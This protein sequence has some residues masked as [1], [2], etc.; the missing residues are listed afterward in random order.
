M[1]KILA[2]AIAP[3]LATAPALA[4]PG[5]TKTNV[6]FRSGPGANF[7][8][9]RSL[10]AGTAVDIGDCDAAGSWCAVAVKGQKGFVSG[11]YLQESKDTD[12]WPRAYTV[13]R[14]RIVLH[15][16]QFTEWTDFKTIEALV[17]A[18][19][20]KSEDARP[21]FGV[22]GLRGETS[23]D[24]D[25][26]EIVINGITITELNFSS[27]GREDLAT[28]ALETGKLLPTGPITVSEARVT[29]SLAEQ[30]RMVD[31]AGL[32]ADPPPIFVST[33]PAILVQTDGTPVYS[34][35]KGKTGLS[36]LVNTN[37]DVFRIDEGGGYI[38]DTTRVG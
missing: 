1:Y 38:S 6:N 30:K 2:L 22:I 32:K 20:A 24:D 5:L 13:G 15:Q 26:G 16:P 36:F 14:G 19:F 31:V 25:K 18:E 27:L 33:A 23:Y 10:P 4:A 11:K 35:V 9:I 29:A 17:A 7:A 8:S 34:P 12:G 37:W 28:L 21:V 3:L